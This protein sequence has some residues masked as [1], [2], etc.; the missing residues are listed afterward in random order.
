MH[1]SYYRFDVPTYQFFCQA[2]VGAILLDGDYTVSGKVLIAPIEG[3][4][5]F[6]AEIGKYVFY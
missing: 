2:T 3:K 1:Q 5:R 6:T 4:G